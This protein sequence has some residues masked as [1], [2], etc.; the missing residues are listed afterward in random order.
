MESVARGMSHRMGISCMSTFHATRARLLA[1]AAVTAMLAVTIAGAVAPG[2]ASAL[3]GS[4]FSAGNIIS[5]D[6]FYDANAMSESAIQAFL[7]A[8][9]GA[10]ANGACLN[11]LQADVD[12][13]PRT[14]SDLTG[15]VRCEAFQG[16]RLAA[17]TIIY[18]AQ[19]A[20]GISAK[21]ILVTL[22][23]EQ[24]L[25]TKTAPSQAALDRAMGMACPDTA[26]CAAYSLGFGNQI[27][28]GTL[29]LKTYKASRFG[30]QP[31]VRAVLWNP[32]RGCGSSSVNIQNYATAALYS[33]TP[34]QPNAAALASLTGLGDACSSYG[35]R[36]FWVY[37]TNWFGSTTGAPPTVSTNL[38]VGEPNLY[39]IART[40]TGALMIYPQSGKGGWGTPGQVGTG[41]SGMT[42]LV[43]AGDFDGDGR[44]DLIARDNSGRLW[45]YGRDGAG[46]WLPRKQIGTGWNAFSKIVSARD[47]DGDGRVDVIA[48]DLSGAL[49]LYPGN[50]TGGW[51]TPSVIGTGWQ[52]FT[53]IIGAGDFNGDG[54]QDLVSVDDSGNVW[55]YDGNGTGGW[56]GTT[57]LATGWGSFVDI[58]SAGDF[59]GDGHPDLFAS[60]AGG[61]LWMYP[62]TVSGTLGARVLAGTG[63]NA[64]TARLG[65]SDSRALAVPPTLPAVDKTPGTGDFDGDGRRDV[66]ARDSAGSLFVYPGNGSS[67]W[68]TSKKLS[69]NWGEFTFIAGVGD[70]NS[71]GYRDS[72]A[73]DSSGELWMY[74]GN[75]KGGWLTRVKVGSGWLGYTAMFGAGDFNGD[76]VP[77]ILA[78]DPAGS[79][80][81]YPGDGNGG[82]LAASRIGSGWSSYGAIFGAGDFNG[83]GKAD[84][85]ARDVAGLLWLYP[86]DGAGG[87]LPRR[88]VGSGWAG[89]TAI[90]AAGDFSG[91]G[92]PDVIARDSAGRLFLYPG[93]GTGGWLQPS[94]I[95]SGW[96]GFSQLG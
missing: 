89:F 81:L 32:N 41:W 16:G 24:G 53:S 79:L 63:W 37:Y 44:Q 87:W 22:Q 46:G 69:G 39:V 88:Q 23:K 85:L 35:N 36:N 77:D 9:I 40:D 6:L 21:V 66:L 70:L 82:W 94:Q 96:N 80:W 3:T 90:F 47:F 56:S 1:M 93:N 52:V 95:G 60:D 43:D 92:F 34:Y 19:V 10:C 5:D 48:R 17:A 86:G 27:Y 58:S 57:L 45:L 74:P 18:R 28:I 8:K 65:P 61:A 62:G 13:R 7:D 51:L 73:V 31:G 20:C 2:T 12:S 26:P 55:L 30:V 14:V 68:L 91:D 84:V 78:R 15:N 50:G 11:V 76:G 29:Q 71:D 38:T 42:A 59:N 75:G 83:D 25:V 49:W 67:G 4:E 72:L 64:I 33:Y 54:H